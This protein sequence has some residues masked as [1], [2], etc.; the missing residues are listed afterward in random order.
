MSDEAT[1]NLLF[2]FAAADTARTEAETAQNAARAANARA[3]EAEF[4]LM[5]A[6]TDKD[7]KRQLNS[8]Q[9]RLASAQSYSD[10]I[11]S[12]L[13][14]KNRLLTEWMHCSEAFK[15]LSHKYAKV[16]GLNPE[17][18]I[19]DADQEILNVAAEDPQFNDTE[20]GAKAKK[21]LGLA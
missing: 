6:K 14:E 10:S 4:A 12:Q 8:M 18:V 11:E 20:I 2:G 17:Q 21:N 19:A 13:K 15:R 7:L 9:I 1:N 16:V 3:Q 5:V